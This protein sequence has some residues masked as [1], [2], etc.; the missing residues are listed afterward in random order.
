M[1]KSIKASLLLLG[2][3]SV[4]ASAQVNPHRWQSP[5]VG[6]YLNDKVGSTVNQITDV[7]KKDRWYST[8]RFKAGYRTYK[9]FDGGYVQFNAR[10]R[11][12]TYLTDRIG[13]IGDLWFRAAENYNKRDG[14]V[15]NKF[16]DFS[17]NT[18][19]EQ[20]RIGF[21]DDTFGALMFGTHT[22]TWSFFAVDMGS[23]ALFDTQGEAGGK[24]PGKILYKNF[25]DN[26]IFLAASY[27]T[28]SDIWG[29]DIGYQEADIY[30]F[31]PD[32]KGIYAA[33]HNGQPMVLV[34]SQYIFGNVDINKTRAGDTDN[35]DTNFARDDTSLYTYSLAGF[36]NYGMKY[37]FSSVF[38]YSKRDKSESLK[39][40]RSQGFAKGGLG[41]SGTVAIEKYPQNHNGFAYIL[42]NTYDEIGKFSVTPQLEYWFGAPNLRAWVSYTWE[43]RADDSVRLETQWDF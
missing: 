15:V 24:N 33:V 20:L 39:D 21:E 12:K 10:L 29:A 18:K 42:Y 31:Q 7:S 14:Q 4:G 25:L 8:Y 17:E 27:D 6:N 28:N 3:F 26:G 9:D 2:F 38:A 43:E 13:F 5:V 34:G 19:W 16:D 37:R 35:S 32:T 30:H 1:N 23:Q 11:G 36:Y 40:I 41:F 22:A